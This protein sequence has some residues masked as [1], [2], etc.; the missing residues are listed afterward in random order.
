MK[1]GLLGQKDYKRR[2]TGDVGPAAIYRWRAGV[3][4]VELRE[5]AVCEMAED[6]MVDA[7]GKDPY[8]HDAHQSFSAASPG[9]RGVF[10][11]VFR[12]LISLPSCSRYSGSSLNG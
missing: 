1:L 12:I 3:I 7:R 11:R 8:I 6:G 2:K 4:P 9:A 5:E 10:S